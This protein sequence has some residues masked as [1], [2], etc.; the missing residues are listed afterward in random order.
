M[1]QTPKAKT[2]RTIKG[3]DQCNLSKNKKKKKKVQKRLRKTKIM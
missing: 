2:N 3:Q 1:K